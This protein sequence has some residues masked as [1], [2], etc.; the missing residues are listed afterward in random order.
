MTPKQIGCPHG[1]ESA[2][3]EPAACPEC[4]ER[5]NARL[6]KKILRLAEA[7]DWFWQDRD[8]FSGAN[9]RQCVVVVDLADRLNELK[10]QV[11]RLELLTDKQAATIERLRRAI[12]VD[13]LPPKP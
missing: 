10:Q 3:G 5:E 7:A 2:D 6:R 12:P 11:A 13:D 4:L 1:W 8:L 9:S